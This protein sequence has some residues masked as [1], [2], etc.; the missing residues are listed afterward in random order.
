MEES[1]V[2]NDAKLNK[3]CK[4]EQDIYY[5]IMNGSDRGLY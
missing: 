4:V 3:H 5:K 2:E 1:S